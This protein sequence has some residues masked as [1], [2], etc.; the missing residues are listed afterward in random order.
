VKL[1]PPSKTN[2]EKAPV[3]N[4]THPM[5]NTT[6]ENVPTTPATTANSTLMPFFAQAVHFNPYERPIEFSEFE[7]M[8]E[9]MSPDNLGMDRVSF[10]ESLKAYEELIPLDFKGTTM[11]GSKHEIMCEAPLKEFIDFITAGVNTEEALGLPTT[12]LWLPSAR[13]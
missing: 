11:H 6:Q 4:N 1:P 12:S 2:P 13:S 5:P 3:D 8:Y 10:G 7:A 9:I